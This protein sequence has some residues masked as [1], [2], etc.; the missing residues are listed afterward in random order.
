MLAHLAILALA[1][2]PAPVSRRRTCGLDRPRVG[3]WT[4]RGA[5]AVYARGE[6]VRVFF[7]LDR[8]AFV[9]VFRVDTD[10]RV[11]V[12]FPREP[13]DDNFARGGRE[14]EVE[15]RS[16]DDAFSI[17]DYPGL[18]YLF[19]VASADAVTYDAIQSRDHWDYRV[20]ADWRE[21]SDTDV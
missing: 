6:R 16:S 2:V 13:W 15:G 8:D 18:G 5:A 19:A 12:L 4:T 20:I 9:T 21:R 10:G 7:K 1:T 3:L 14:L 11:R 17:D